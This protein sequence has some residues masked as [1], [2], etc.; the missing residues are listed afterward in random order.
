[1]R[2]FSMERTKSRGGGSYTY[3]KYVLRY[4]MVYERKWYR[5]LM[6]PRR[7]GRYDGWL[8]ILAGVIAP[9]GSAENLEEIRQNVP[10]HAFFKCLDPPSNGVTPRPRW[11]EGSESET[12]AGEVGDRCPTF[13]GMCASDLAR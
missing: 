7:L 1:M 10:P 2:L 4:L 9:L 12:T 11:D 8:G 3:F 6:P 13:Q 5:P